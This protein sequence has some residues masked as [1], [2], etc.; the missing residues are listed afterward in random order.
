MSTGPVGRASVPIGAAVPSLVRWGLS[1]DADLVFR[2]MATFG[3][4]SAPRL[5]A[6]LGVPVHRVDGALAELLTVGAAISVTDQR[7]TA[8]PAPVWATR[9]PEDVV[10][11]LRSRRLRPVDAQR[12]A[13]AHH[14]SV[15]S[16]ADR[17]SSMAGLLSGP[18]PT[19][20][21]LGEGVRYLATREA[22]RERLAELMAV[23]RQ[24]HLA[25][26]TEQAFDAASARAATPL[27]RQI[28]ERGVRMRVIGLPPADGDLHVGAD[29]MAHPRCGYREQPQVPLKL[30]VI[31]HKVAFFP[32][33]PGDLTRGYLEISQP[34]VVRALVM[35]F[36]HHWANAVNPREH[37]MEEIVLDDRERELIR[38]L[39]DG[40]TDVSAAEQLRI[41]TR[42]VT[43][44][45]RG[46]M[47]RLGVDNRFQLG[48]ALGAAH[49]ARPSRRFTAGPRPTD[50]QES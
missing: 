34:G 6:E 7:R 42:S 47:D 37:G 46:V 17:R 12:Q 3:P 8:R 44:I 39:A 20:G 23:E 50:E 30:V 28:L 13:R 16:L 15:M 2:T 41:S 31:D 45:L 48:L 35:L 26:N 21:L 33:D 36:E 19:G 29:S 10:A 1:C 25:I 43:N 4:R 14:R 49:V 32:A 18:G 22:A 11:M 38:L 27:D 9:S 5:A 24:E 40:H